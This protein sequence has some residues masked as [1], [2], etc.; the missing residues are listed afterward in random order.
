MPKLENGQAY[1]YIMLF[2]SG[3]I[4]IG[5]TTDISSRIKQ[6]SNSNSGGYKLIDI[7]V[8][9]PN[10]IARTIEKYMH[11]LY[12][13]NRM[14]GEFFKGISFK[15]ACKK[16]DNILNSEEFNNCNTVRMDF[17]NTSKKILL[18]GVYFNGNRT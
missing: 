2:N 15:K 13:N 9:K 8:S 11:H 7:Y 16:L 5:F 17:Y 1:N 14:E 4:K 12:R 3:N 18:E 6:L 10:Y